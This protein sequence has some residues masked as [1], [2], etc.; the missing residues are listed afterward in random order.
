MTVDKINKPFQKF[1]TI[2]ALQHKLQIN[3]NASRL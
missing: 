2:F 1:V 3:S